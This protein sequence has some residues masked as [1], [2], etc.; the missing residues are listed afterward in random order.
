MKK[1]LALFRVSLKSLLLTSTGVGRGRK[2]KTMSGMGVMALFAFLALYIS[3][4]YSSLLLEVLAPIG[5]EGMV[6]IYMGIA[7]VVGGLLYT[8]FAVKG[9]VFGG[10]DNDLLLSMPVSSTMLMASRVS[11]IYLESFI[12][13]FFMLVP[14]GVACAIFTETGVGHSVLFWVRLLIASVALP[15][16]DTA[17]SVAIGAVMAFCSAKFSR[18][19]ALGQNLF[20][21]L[22]LA[23]VFWFSFSLNRLMAELAAN[24][25]QIKENFTWGT[26]FVWLADG[27]LGEW[28]LL[29]GFVAC[30]VIPFVLMVVIL[31]K[32]YRK[33]VTAFQSQTAR[34]DYKLSS[35]S[36]A[37]QKKALLAK[38]SRRF[39]GNT[40]YFWNAGMGLIMLLILSAA[41]LIKGDVVREILA[42][43]GGMVPA[44][45]L[46]GAAMGFC[47]S[48]CCITAPS[49][50]LEGKYLWILREAPVKEETILW[51][52]IGFQ[53][54][55]TLPC[56]LIASV[57]LTAALRLPLWQ[58][59]MLF[60]AMAAFAVG[61][62]CFGM[63]MGLTF[64]RLDA[65]NDTVVIKQSASVLLAMFVPMAALAA[66]GVVCWAG[67]RLGEVAALILPTVFLGALA[68]VCA[69]IL[70]TKGPK[71]F[72]S[73]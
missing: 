37:G 27:I 59:V 38:E 8:T 47:L 39:F 71:M 7:A 10:K 63:L 20:M 32:M 25:Q 70:R 26:P 49:V 58:G 4:V 48:T 40:A 57:C 60:V 17:L 51:V 23:L 13:S 41:A 67:G 34:S 46:C 15:L 14:A 42:Q 55:L 53:L 44:A 9:I 62:A 61:Q 1:F 69:A 36:A 12:F 52:K 65:A 24:A 21:G 2:K 68:A 72:H 5:M 28:T 11:A 73:L 66:A 45:P 64:P 19:K 56:T 50:S 43:L 3:G 31:G 16:L 30:C 29:L 35:Q 6:F 33:A 22:F 18:G 54:L